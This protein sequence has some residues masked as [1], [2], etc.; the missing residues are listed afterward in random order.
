MSENVR[1]L[2]AD[3]YVTN[4]KG[5]FEYLLGGSKDKKL[6][7]VRVFDE[8]TKR[9]AYNKQTQEAQA[10][11]TSNCPL[12]AHGE[13]ANKTKIYGFKEMDADHVSAW[14]KGGDSSA[15][16]CEMLCITHNRSKGN[17]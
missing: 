8:K 13:N 2:A 15:K 6:L 7:V 11:G 14:S 12:C 17:R 9:V 3:E 10:K 16:N 4:G 5:I 1:R